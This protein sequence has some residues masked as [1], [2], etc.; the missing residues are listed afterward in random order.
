VSSFI[1]ELVAAAGRHG[2]PCVVV[3]GISKNGNGHAS[4]DED[5]DDVEVVAPFMAAPDAGGDAEEV[6]KLRAQVQKLT[7]ELQRPSAEARAAPA[8]IPAGD[9]GSMED[10]SVEVLGFEDDKLTK[11]LMRQGYETIGKLRAGC[12]ALA[13]SKLKKDWLIEIGMKLAG[14]GPSSSSP[15]PAGAAV[16]ASDAPLGHTDRP[17]LERLAAAQQKQHELDAT[18]TK[19]AERQAQAAKLVKAGK[20]VPGG[21][22]DELIKL[23]EDILT[24][25]AKS[26]VLRWAMNLDCDPDISLDES[27]RRANLGPWMSSPQPRLA[28]QQ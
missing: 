15:A 4:D 20:P 18:R 3:G 27:L 13:E 19:H 17:W 8:R 12:V 16:S 5:E 14:A 10:Q 24:D 21:L 23:D 9:Y 7:A 28:P 22:D 2:V 11:T 1:D 6:A 25:T 26:V